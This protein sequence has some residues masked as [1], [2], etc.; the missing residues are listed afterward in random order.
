MQVSA[1]RLPLLGPCNAVSTHLCAIIC[2]VVRL[3]SDAAWRDIDDV[4]MRLA[5]SAGLR[6]RRVVNEITSPDPHAVHRIAVPL[7][8]DTEVLPGGTLPANVRHGV[9]KI[10]DRVS[11][12][13]KIDVMLLLCDG[14]HDK[15]CF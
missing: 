15:R 2:R 4:G 14:I 5:S 7:P 8:D 1:E 12:G 9:R 10:H 3:V 6:T 13:F 11:T